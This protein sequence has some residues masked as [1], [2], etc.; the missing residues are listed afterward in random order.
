M[1]T[2]LYYSPSTQRMLVVSNEELEELDHDTIINTLI[3]L[4]YELIGYFYDN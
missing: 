3:Y 4:N 2:S 1:L